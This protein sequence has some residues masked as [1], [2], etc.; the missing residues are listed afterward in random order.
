MDHLWITFVIGAIHRTFFAMYV[1]PIGPSIIILSMDLAHD[2]IRNSSVTGTSGTMGAWVMG[3]CL[4]T[5]RLR[6]SQLQLIHLIHLRT[7]AP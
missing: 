5:C 7:I 1:L 3:L 2:L 4:F 6:T